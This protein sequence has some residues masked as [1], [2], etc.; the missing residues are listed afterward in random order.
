MAK[1]KKNTQAPEDK[2]AKPFYYKYGTSK[3]HILAKTQTEANQILAKNKL[4]NKLFK[5]EKP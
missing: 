5:P 1:Q 2:K 3:I 4:L